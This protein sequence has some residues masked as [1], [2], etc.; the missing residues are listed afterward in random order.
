M[1]SKE[2]VRPATPTQPDLSVWGA[3]TQFGVAGTVRPAG[4]ASVRQ[5]SAFDVCHVG[6]VLRAVLGVQLI[7]GLGSLYMA[8]APEA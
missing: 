3:T 5:P 2:T 7:T 8:S 1:D 6:V 4:Q